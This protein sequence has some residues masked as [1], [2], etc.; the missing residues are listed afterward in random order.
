MRM[1]RRP[2]LTWF[3]MVAVAGMASS[4]WSSDA[5]PRSAAVINLSMEDYRFEYA[6]T[7]PQERVIFRLSN[8]GLKEHELVIVALPD[9]YP[10]LGEE[11]SVGS[12]VATV[13]HIPTLSPGE[14]TKFAVD[15]TRG[16]YAFVCFI[17]DDDG[18]TH[19]SR[20]MRSEFSVL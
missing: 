6:Q 8:A 5:L 9:D 2:L 13:A 19:Y 3:L 4:C 7:V 11:P 18:R 17:E 12:V 16:R 15:F 14:S 20:G 10:A 1:A